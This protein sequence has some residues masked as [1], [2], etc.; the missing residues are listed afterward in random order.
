VT[1][2][3]RDLPTHASYSQ[4]DTWMT[5]GEKYWLQKATDIPN[6]PSWALLGGSTVHSLT[7]EIDRDLF[8]RGVVCAEGDIEQRFREH[9]AQ[10]LRSETERNGYTEDQIMASGRASKAWPEKENRAWWEHHGPPMIRSWIEWQ[11]VTPWQLWQTPAGEWA[12]EL[13]LEVQFGGGPIK[14]AIDRVYEWAGNLIVVD[15]KSGRE[16]I[17]QFQLGQYA[18]AIEQELGVRPGYGSY[19]MARTGESTVAHPLAQYSQSYIDAT[20]RKFR[21]AKEHGLFMPHP[22]NLCGSCGVREFCT[23]K[24]TRA[25]EIPRSY[26]EV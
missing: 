20:F 8:E 18:A 6:K 22:S 3:L 11:K 19:W 24:G 10:H 25:H 12:I 21:I 23:A 15:I 14:L 26:M 16:P 1:V 7:E 13:E 5:C 9:L 17:N 2:T 4:L